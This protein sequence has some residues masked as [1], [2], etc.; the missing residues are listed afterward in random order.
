[1]RQYRLLEITVQYD[2]YL[3]E[4]YTLH[5]DFDKW[6]YDELYAALVEDAFVSIVWFWL[7]DYIHTIGL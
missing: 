2:Q 4:F 5:K 1:M 7:L 6:S 3:R